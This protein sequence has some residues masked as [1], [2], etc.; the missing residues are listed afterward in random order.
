[1]YDTSLNTILIKNKKITVLKL[2]FVN[3]IHN[4][5]LYRK[6]LGGSGEKIK[7]GLAT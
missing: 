3:G 5:T 1:M 4:D 2:F 6:I 7:N